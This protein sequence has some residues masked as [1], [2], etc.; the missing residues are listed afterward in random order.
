MTGR[1]VSKT[2]GILR[3]FQNVLPR[4]SKLLIRPQLGHGDIIHDPACNFTFH[5]KLKSF[6]CNA[7]LTITGNIKRIPK[8]KLYRSL[9]LESLQLRRWYRE[10]CCLIKTDNSK[11]SDYILTP[12]LNR[13]SQTGG[14]FHISQFKVKHNY[15]ENSCDG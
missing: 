12:A 11:S 7:S 13:S 1:G 15:F 4:T 10:L 3:K 2:V 6:R 5:K 9:G 8:E 14:N